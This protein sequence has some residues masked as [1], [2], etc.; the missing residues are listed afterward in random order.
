MAQ[1][2]F[3]SIVAGIASA[4]LSGILTPGSMLAAILM[5]VAPLPLMIVGLGWHALV[6]ALGALVGCLIMSFGMGPKAALVYGAM[7]GLP[8]WLLCEWLPRLMQNIRP[9]SAEQAGRQVGTGLFGAI[10]GY[11]IAVTFFGALTIDTDHSRFVQRVSRSVEV[12]FRA[13]FE[14][15]RAPVPGGSKLSDMAQIYAL[16]MPPMLTFLICIMLTLSLWLAVRIVKKSERLA[17]PLLPAY[18]LSLPKE[19]LF[20][21]LGGMGLASVVGYAGMLGALVMVAASFALMLAGLSLI[22]Y[23]TLGRSERPL[24]LGAAWGAL[25]V[26]GFPGFIYAFVGA[27]DAA[28]DF[29]RPKGGSNI[30]KI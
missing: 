22:H 27:L 4:L 23:K 14:D 18:F 11:A 28:L 9:L 29:R 19:A 20:V 5:F 13:M 7:V 17:F 16:I 25:L 1:A 6:A 15:G 21:F 2:V 12:M 26:I 8:S 3:L 24:V 30:P 10:S